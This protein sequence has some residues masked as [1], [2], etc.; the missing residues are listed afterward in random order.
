MSTIFFL[1][2][3]QNGHFSHCFLLVDWNTS[4]MTTLNNKY[5]LLTHH[6]W[7]LTWRLHHNRQCSGQCH[8]QCSRILKKRNSKLLNSIWYV[9]KIPSSCRSSGVRSQD[10]MPKNRPFKLLLTSRRKHPSRVGWK[11][12]RRQKILLV[13]R[14]YRKNLDGLVFR[15]IN[16][17]Y[18]LYKLPAIQVQFCEQ[19]RLP[20][21]SLGI[22][23]HSFFSM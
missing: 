21:R 17:T 20:L 3:Q 4:S 15:N 22:P 10:S 14:C 11:K 7:I 5:L 23:A 9:T 18:F 6:R 16:Y 12:W 19:D 1:H 2:F 8:R 13:R